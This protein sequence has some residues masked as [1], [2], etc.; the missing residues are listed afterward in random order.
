METAPLFNDCGNLLFPNYEGDYPDTNENPSTGAQDYRGNGKDNF[1]YSLN[2]GS[3]SNTSAT[4]QWF[5]NKYATAYETLPQQPPAQSPECACCGATAF[6]NS[7]WVSQHV[8]GVA[9]C[10]AC[11]FR[12][13][14]QIQINSTRDHN[15]DQPSPCE[16]WEEQAFPNNHEGMMHQNAPTMSQSGYFAERKS[17]EEVR[18]PVDCWCA[19]RQTGN[20]ME[21]GH[22]ELPPPFLIWP[23]SNNPLKQD[24]SA[25]EMLGM[26]AYSCRKPERVTMCANCQTSATTLWRRNAEGE[27]VCNACGLYFKLHKVNRPLSMKKEAIQKRKSR[28]KRCD[29]R[30]ACKSSLQQQQAKFQNG[31]SNDGFGAV[32]EHHQ[33]ANDDYYFL[34]SS[35]PPR[36]T[37]GEAEDVHRAHSYL[38]NPTTLAYLLPN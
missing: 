16:T 7:F 21:I 1:G 30:E 11:Q 3:E 33:Q 2:G 29:R 37:A 27:P 32:I 12:Q 22:Q 36:Q 5:G 34:E 28:K 23:V 17:E 38:T 25:W 6:D 24:L 26:L 35:S 18:E 10:E 31:E 8:P 13:Q 15:Q 14:Q 19:D 20:S 4:Y 9:L